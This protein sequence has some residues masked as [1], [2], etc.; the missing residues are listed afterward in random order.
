MKN[1]ITE[2]TLNLIKKNPWAALYLPDYLKND[3]VIASI[4]LQLDGSTLSFFSENIQNNKT[5]V[6]LAVSNNGPSI[7]YA[8]DKLKADYDIMTTAIKQDR[9]ALG[10]IPV[11][12][13]EQ[14]KKYSDSYYDK[15]IEIQLPQ[16]I[17]E[18]SISNKIKKRL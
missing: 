8:S 12:L 15:K 5:A 14:M 4:C 16:M 3:I 11:H 17:S 6:M 9:E 13:F 10:Y 2:D 18:E 7:R 1:L